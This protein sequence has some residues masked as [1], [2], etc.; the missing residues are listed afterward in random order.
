[1]LKSLTLTWR[2]ILMTIELL[3]N[4]CYYLST[5]HSDLKT[6]TSKFILYCCYNEIQSFMFF[7]LTFYHFI[8]YLIYAYTVLIC[9]FAQSKKKHVYVYKVNRIIVIHTQHTHHR[10]HIFFFL[11]IALS[12]IFLPPIFF[13]C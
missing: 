7:F 5:T 4:L 11:N 12:F 3:I 13:Y 10:M 1:M 8:P 2:E 9:D 6:D